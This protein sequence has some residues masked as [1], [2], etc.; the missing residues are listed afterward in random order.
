MVR[1]GHVRVL[2]LH[3]ANK[4]AAGEVV[5]RPAGVVKELIENAIDAGAGSISVAIVQGGR[6]LIAVQDDGSGMNRD[7]ALLALERQATS[8]ILDV[9]DIERVDTLG[10]RGEALPSIASISRFSLCTR[11]RDSDEGV[12]LAVGCGT[13]ESVEPAGCPPGTRVEVRDLFCNV[14]A[15]RKFLRAYATEEGY[16]RRV[17]TVHALAYPDIAFQ[18]SADGREVMRLSA[19]G[20]LADRLTDLFGV[21]FTDSLLTLGGN[22]GEVSVSGYIE[23]PDRVFATRREQYVFV[24]GRPATAPVIAAAVREAYPRRDGDSRPALVMF[25]RL[26]ADQV[27]V[28]V[29]PTK[30]EVRFRNAQAVRAAIIG[31][32]RAAVAAP[33]A[34]SAASPVA[35]SAVSP[36]ATASVAATAAPATVEPDGIVAPEVSLPAAPAAPARTPPPERPEAAPVQALLAVDGTPVAA[37]PWQWFEVLACTRSGFVLIETEAGIVAI[38]PKAAFARI[39]YE[40]LM[41]ADAAAPAVSQPLLMPVVLTMPPADFVRI[42]DS[43][44]ALRTMG[45]A[46]EEFGRD[47]FKVE[48]LPQLLGEIPPGPVLE[49]IA[50]DFAESG[51]RRAGERWREQL[52]A[53]SIARAFAVAKTATDRDHAR[54][55]VEDLCRCRLPYVSPQGRPTMYFMSNRELSRRFGL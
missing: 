16:V 49:T 50:Q 19:A 36:A 45:F 29:H 11:R 42:R 2:P 18:L 25:L 44:D 10:F 30:R 38:N 46:I 47:T 5:E 8:K 31:A 37:R 9:D 39:A 28:N 14:P 54:R 20:T 33:V 48:A 24:N 53:K 51:G 21:E 7:D 1:D 17:L 6:K 40:R 26:G 4:I 52:L 41:D 22:D 32:I 3:V 13:L 55:L 43:V 35:A 34:A 27:D 23:R 15:R 12:R